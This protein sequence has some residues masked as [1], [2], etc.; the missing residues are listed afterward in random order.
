MPFL[1][2]DADYFLSFG[3]GPLTDEGLYTMQLKNFLNHG[4]F[5]MT[6]VD[7]LLK[8]PLFNCILFPV[9]LVF[10]SNLIIT[11][12]FLTLLVLI[13]FYFFTKQ[14]N[15]KFSNTFFLITVL[16]QFHIF[17]YTHLA[18]SDMLGISFILLGYR[19]Y[20][21]SMETTSKKYLLLSC[22]FIAASYFTKLIFIYALFIIPFSTFTNFLIAEKGNRQNKF[23]LFKY[24]CFYTLVFVLSYFLVWY[25]PNQH[26]FN[27]VLKMQSDYSAKKDIHSLWQRFSDNLNF[28]RK[29]SYFGLNVYLLYLNICLVSIVIIINK[30]LHVKKLIPLF[31]FTI[32][33]LLF[34]MIKYTNVYLP[35]RY[36]IA[37]IVAN[38]LLLSLVI[39]SIILSYPEFKKWI[40][41]LA[42]ALFLYNLFFYF[43][44]LNRKQYQLKH[45]NDY[46]SEIDFGNK[47]IMGNWAPS[48]TWSSKAY[49]KTLQNDYSAGKNLIK[50]DKPKA[51]ITE[52][53][54]NESN[55][56]FSRQGI[57][58]R[59][60]ADSTRTFKVSYWTL[61]VY[62]M[63][64]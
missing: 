24:S 8:T 3:R 21:I 22:A 17:H 51:I 2:A 16:L 6:D 29:D 35:S 31:I 15:N 33:W 12:L 46:F 26:F 58:L 54:E 9:F 61:V 5:D 39:Q 53:D 37:G 11:R 56:I 44:S 63:K 64:Q 34:E 60:H 13:C 40:I 28:Y 32:Y 27:F 30:K 38:L 62:W 20:A 19:A 18:L 7:G 42:C 49:T 45:I 50:I 23:N 47:P 1:D 55:E 10:G 41:T 52:L 43:Q 57:N 25:L 48:C 36:V 4:V 14:P 59:E